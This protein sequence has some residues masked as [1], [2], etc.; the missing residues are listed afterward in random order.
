MWCAERPSTNASALVPFVAIHT[1]RNAEPIRGHGARLLTHVRTLFFGSGPIGMVYAHLLNQAG[2]DVTML[3]RG[4][5]LDLFAGFS[6]P[7]SPKWPSP[8]TPPPRGTNSG[9]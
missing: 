4:E 7:A 1:A 2:A 3:A 6:N 5:K 9:N 8:N